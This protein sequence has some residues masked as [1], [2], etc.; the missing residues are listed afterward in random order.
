M[1]EHEEEIIK[2]YQS[3]ENDIVNEFCINESNLCKK[4]KSKKQEL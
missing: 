2:L 3:G 1:E 4:F